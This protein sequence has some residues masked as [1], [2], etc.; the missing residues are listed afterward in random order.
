M[1]DSK[2]FK[3]IITTRSCT[4]QKKPTK[5]Q[6]VALKGYKKKKGKGGQE[7]IYMPSR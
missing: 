5:R 1:A 7:K 2:N 4:L 3:S 6:E